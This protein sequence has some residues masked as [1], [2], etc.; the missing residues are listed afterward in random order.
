MR[1]LRFS[2]NNNEELN[3]W[4]NGQLDPNSRTLVLVQVSSN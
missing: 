2:F 1:D 3:I 4:A